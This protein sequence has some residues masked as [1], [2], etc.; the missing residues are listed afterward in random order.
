MRVM[1]VT[2][3][4]LIGNACAANLYAYVNADG[5]YVVT[6]KRPRSVDE[7]SVLSDE[8]EFIRFV[9][10][11]ESQVP[12]GHWRPWFI[13]KEPHPFDGPD[14]I[15]REAEPDI[16]IEEVDDPDTREDG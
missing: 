8:G 11:R 2:L 13:P 14:P 9:S 4:L 12:I 1:L 3:A 16:R 6:K 15:E 5:D 7:F 10:R